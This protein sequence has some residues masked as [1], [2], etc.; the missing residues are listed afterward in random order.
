MKFCYVLLAATVLAAPLAFSHAASA[1]PV[2]GPY[3]SLGAGYNIESSQRAKN[4]FVNGAGI[5]GAGVGHISTN[6]GYDITGAA[7]YGFGN[8]WRVELEG[9]YINNGFN[10]FNLG[11]VD[12]ATNG[13]EGRYGV[14]TNGYYDFDVGLPYLFPYLGAGIGYQEDAF[15]SFTPGGFD[16]NKT[17]GAFAYQGIAG[18]A[19][20][21]PRV[22]GL[23][24]TV[25][26]RFIA[27]TGSRKYN[28]G[29]CRWASPATVQGGQRVQQLDQGRP[30]LP[31]VHAAARAAGPGARSG[32]RS[33]PG[34]GANLPGVLR[35][36]SVQSD[37]ARDADHRRGRRRQPHP[38]RHHAE[39]VRLHRHVRHAAIQPGPVDAPRQ[40]GCR[41]SWS[42]MACRSRRSRSTL[43]ARRTCWCRPAPACAS[44]RT[45]AS[46]SFSSKRFDFPKNPG[47]K[48][49]GL[50]IGAARPRARTRWR[51]RAQRSARIWSVCVR[52]SVL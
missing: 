3:V 1:Q 33:G 23:S 48:P 32:C 49:P 35:L 12:L 26:Y 10:K 4:I 13:H 29:V 30:A 44:R 21:I 52:R 45:A 51:G 20:P 47:G 2:T 42:P 28:G 18:L 17:K 27:L 40:G 50:F 46:K 11:G 5:P 14:F 9:D 43:T 22:P 15:N 38:E 16:F 37:A 8:G 25:E 36:G 34:P 19:F 6:N 31:A 39:R 41:D 24:A 7:G